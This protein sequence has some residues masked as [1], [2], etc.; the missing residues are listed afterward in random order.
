MPLGNHSKILLRTPYFMCFWF[1]LNDK[2]LISVSWLDACLCAL[3]MSSTVS[4]R[5]RTRSATPNPKGKTSPKATKTAS[6]I[7]SFDACFCPSFFKKTQ[8]NGLLYKIAYVLLAWE[9]GWIATPWFVMTIPWPP[10]LM[11]DFAWTLIN[12]RT[13]RTLFIN[14]IWFIKKMCVCGKG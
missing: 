12:I 7:P 8:P 10:R 14:T 13:L 6:S 9:H 1:E 3:S 11:S 5:T 4:R 2:S